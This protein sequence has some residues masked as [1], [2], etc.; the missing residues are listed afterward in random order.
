[1]LYLLRVFRVLVVVI[2]VLRM[3][4]YTCAC[5]SLRNIC[6]C[7]CVCVFD[8]SH[9]YIVLHY[10]IH[11]LHHMIQ[12]TCHIMSYNELSIRNFLTVNTTII[13]NILA[14]CCFAIG[15]SL[16]VCVY[17]L[18][19]LYVTHCTVRVWFGGWYMYECMY[20]VICVCVFI[21]TYLCNM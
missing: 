20:Y 16:C 17:V 15:L 12:R 19:M 5:T 7:E 1:M 6:V 3:N 18:V 9:V 14:L 2:C 11:T 4:T 10:I 8:K 21:Y 13:I